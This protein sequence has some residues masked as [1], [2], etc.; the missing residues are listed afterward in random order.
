MYINTSGII[1]H[2]LK[3]G[4]SS[5]IIT[6]YTLGFGRVSYLVHGVNKKKS[7]TRLAFF[8]PLSVVEMEVTHQPAK[9]LQYIKEIRLNYV[10]T[11]IPYN[12]IK[13]SIALFLSE[14]LYRI[15]RQVEVDERLYYFLKNS[16][17]TLDSSTG[18]VSNFHLIFLIQ[19]SRY[20]GFEPNR[21]ENNHLYFDLL[22]GVFQKEKPHHLHYLLPEDAALFEQCLQTDF[23]TMQHL[24]LTRQQRVQLLE[25]LVDYYKLH[26]PNFHGLKS[27][28]VLQNLFD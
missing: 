11:S 15:L 27:L 10:F 21:E 22:N 24:K 23:D 13:N 18:S 5:T 6:V 8:Q 17:E 1:L 25:N 19:L 14:V 7:T 9:E 26:V 12:P 4:D 16:I 28:E 2:N 20:L 3:Y